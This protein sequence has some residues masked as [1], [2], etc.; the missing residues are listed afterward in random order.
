MLPTWPRHQQST[1]T[2]AGHLHMQSCHAIEINVQHFEPSR[3]ESL[4]DPFSRDR[5]AKKAVL[6]PP[7]VPLRSGNARLRVLHVHTGNLRGGVE[8]TLRLLAL[9]H[10]LCPD[11]E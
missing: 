7:E 1:R 3:V 5:P 2:G 10:G 6:T 4:V 8:T 11:V 9:E